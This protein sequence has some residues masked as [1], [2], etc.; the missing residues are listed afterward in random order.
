M[1]I[2]RSHILLSK[3]SELAFEP[4]TCTFSL[5]LPK[6]TLGDPRGDI[7]RVISS[8]KEELSSKHKDEQRIDVSLDVARRLTRILRDA[9]FQVS[10]VLTR[11]ENGYELVDVRQE[12]VTPLGV[13]IDIG[14]TVVSL[15]LVDLTE[16]AII[17]KGIVENPQIAFGED[18]LT[19]IHFCQ[20]PRGL[21]ILRESVLDCINKAVVELTHE[22]GISPLDIYAGS[23]AGNPSM[24]HLLLGLDPYHLC[25]EP[26]VPVYNQTLEYKAKDLNLSICRDAPVYLFPNLGSYFGGDVVAGILAS[27]MYRSKSSSILV[28]VGTNAEIVLGNRDWF[29]VCAGAAGPALESGGAKAGMRAVAGAIENVHIDRDTLEPR[30]DVIG[31]AGPK[32]ICGSGL[33]DL[34]AELF[35]SEILDAKGRFSDDCDSPRVLMNGGVRGYALALASRGECQADIIIDEADIGNLLKAKGAMYTAL[36]LIT[37]RLGVPF[38]ELESFFVA[39]SFGE[40]INP[41]HAVTIGML[42]DIPQEKFKVLGNS[43][44]LGACLMLIS[45]GL[46]EEIEDIRRK[47]T[48]IQLTTD[49]EFMNRL[50]AALFIPHTQAEL[51]PSV[52][53]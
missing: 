11:N 21:E 31:G 35:S 42:P 48:Y 26:Y 7:D 28:D 46:R 10:A 45:H 6:P 16:G 8:L 32:G 30:Y 9:S 41:Q 37:E 17:V 44:G 13:A 51:F 27:G 15:Y 33:I 39:G 36:S 20:K 50:S 22:A 1:L 34:V 43:A 5:D 19:R 23:I 3:K 12:S 53:R 40:H 52:K 47:A 29:V 38:S 2:D 49:N 25:R 4:M 18:I 14:T 24:T